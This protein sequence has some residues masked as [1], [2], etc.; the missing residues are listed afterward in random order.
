MAASSQS[1]SLPPTISAHPVATRRPFAVVVAQRTLQRAM[2]LVIA[3]AGV[4]LATLTAERAVATLALR[5]AERTGLRRVIA[6]STVAVAAEP[7]IMRVTVTR[8][9]VVERITRRG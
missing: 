8:T 1:I 5:A 6:P 7:A 2:P 3:S 4:A 9:T